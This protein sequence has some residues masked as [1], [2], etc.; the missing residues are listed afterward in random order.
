MRLALLMVLRVENK[1]TKDTIG[2][3]WVDQAWSWFG[4]VSWK[5]AGFDVDIDFKGFIIRD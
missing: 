3:S 2:L 4:R 1:G 5:L